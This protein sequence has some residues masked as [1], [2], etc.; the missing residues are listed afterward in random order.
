MNACKQ[1]P[2]GYRKA[3]SLDLQTDRKLRIKITA[4]AVLIILF[5]GLYGN[6]IQ[7]IQRYFRGNL[8][9]VAYA[10]LG[11][12]LYL[13]LH[14]VVHGFF[15]WIFGRHPA[16]FGLS[17]PF[18]SARSQIYFNKS[19]Y[20]IIALAPI[21]IWGLVL[22]GLCASNLKSDWFWTFYIIEIIN[23]SGAASDVYVAGKFLQLSPDVLIRDEGTAINVYVKA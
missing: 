10:F 2:Y 4:S 6:S 19:Q 11:I 23:I 12:I 7:P 9:Q 5:M 18:T 13:I 14:E 20:M 15:M 8:N 3:L 16:Q 21:V 17:M 1:L 22:W